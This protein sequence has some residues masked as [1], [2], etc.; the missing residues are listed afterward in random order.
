[1]V[2]FDGN[3]WHASH[4]NEDDCDRLILITFFE[5]ITLNGTT[6]NYPIPTMRSR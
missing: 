4:I 5:Q 1:M 3:E 6:I 2:Y